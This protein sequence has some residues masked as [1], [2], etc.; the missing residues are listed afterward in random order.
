MRRYHPAHNLGH[1]RFLE[2][3][4]LAADG[5][6][7]GDLTHWDEIRFPFV[8]SLTKVIDLA[9]VEVVHDSRGAPRSTSRNRVASTPAA[10]SSSRSPNLTAGYVRE[11]RLG[12]WGERSEPLKPGRRRKTSKAAQK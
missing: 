12:H 10:R 9:G 5:R 11:Y 6:P 7:A 4:H 1:F 2:C 8:P 3:S